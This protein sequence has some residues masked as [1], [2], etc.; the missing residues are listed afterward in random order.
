MVSTNLQERGMGAKFA[1]VALG[2]GQAPLATRL[3]EDGLREGNWVFLANCH[4][5]TSWLPT[6][7]KL[8]ESFESRSPH[9]NFRWVRGGSLMPLHGSVTI[10]FSIHAGDVHLRT[11]AEIN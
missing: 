5:M 11:W 1:T 8:I 4:L 9:D 7:D 6:L 10:N 3:I 2:Q